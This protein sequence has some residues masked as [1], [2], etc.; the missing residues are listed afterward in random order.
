MVKVVV[1]G[2]GTSVQGI[3]RGLTRECLKIGLTG[4]IASGK[5]TIGKAIEALGIKTIDAD[6]IVEDL[7]AHDTELR[8]N[9]QSTFGRDVFLP[10]GSVDKKKL[11]ALAFAD[12]S[13]LKLLETWIHP[14]VRQRINQF[15]QACASDPLAVAQVP[16]LFESKLE[17][18][19]DE[20]WVIKATRDQQK[21][22]LLKRDP[23]L[24]EAQAD[25]RIDSQMPLAE[26]LAKA[27]VV[28][29]N[30]G[31]PSATTTQVDSL[32]RSKIGSN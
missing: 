13:K 29:D 31:L 15:F 7:Y 30:T 28:I 5:S 32:I 20:V 17:G 1:N 21:Q 14:K 8:Q 9:V 23:H 10:S 16:L 6:V 11:G 25:A 27:T 2:D 22:R 18:M 19:F 24:T 12:R 26:K 3:Q 4:G